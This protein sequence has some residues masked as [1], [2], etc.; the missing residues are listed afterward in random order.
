MSKENLQREIFIDIKHLNSLLMKKMRCAHEG[1]NKDLNPLS[2]LI[3][4]FLFLNQN[5][6]IYQ[7]DI[8]EEFMIN[9]SRLSKILSNLE[10]ADLVKRVSS[11][12]DARFKKIVLGEKAKKINKNILKSKEELEKS[13]LNGV[14][15]KELEIFYNVLDKIENNLKRT[16]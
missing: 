11:K 16:L 12:E 4:K 10:K 9:K 5:I 14:T 15:E 2:G 13:M 7:K 8:E 1:L 6:D 3:L